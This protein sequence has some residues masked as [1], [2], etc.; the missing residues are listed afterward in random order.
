MKTNRCELFVIALL[1]VLLCLAAGRLQAAVP[2]SGT[3]GPSATDTA[4]TGQF[5]AVA[6]TTV[7]EECPAAADPANLLC[8]H[9]FLTVDVAPEYW[10]THTGGVEITIN[11]GDNGND[12]DMYVYDSS[13]V[14]VGSSGAGGTTSERVFI[15]EASGTYEVRVVPFLIVNSGYTGAAGF[16]AQDGGPAPNPVRSDGGLRFS[17]ATV[18]DAQRTEGEPL[19]YIDPA[20]NY[21][22]SGPY[23]A[24]TAQ[25][26]IHRSVDAGLQFNIVSPIGLRP[27]LPPGGGDTDLVVDDQG[28]AY[29][30]DL[31]ALI[32][33]GVAVSNDNGN[34]W[35]KNILGVAHTIDDR[36]WFAGDNGT[37]PAAS[38]NTVFLAYRQVPLGSFIFSTPGSTGF[39]DPVGGLVYQ[40]ASADPVNAVSQGAPCG[41][42]RFDP[43]HRNLYYPCGAG[44]HV[45]I[46][47]GHV[48]PGQRTGIEFYNVQ[49][50]ASPGGGPVGDIFPG[51]AVDRAG[52][53]YATW[54]DETDHNVYFAVS[55]DQ[56]AT[57]GPALQVNGN[58]ANSN[59]FPWVQAGEE[60]QIV[61]TWLGSTSHLDSDNMPSWY[62]DRNAAAAFPWFG[63]VA[64][65]RDAHTATPEFFQQRFTDKPMHYGE[66]CNSGLACST[67]GGD[68]TMADFFAVALDVDGAMR[69]VYNDT[70]SQHHGAHIFEVR[71]LGGPTAVGTTLNRPA[72]ANPM[73]DATGDAQSPHYQPFLGAGPSLPQFDFTELRLSQPDTDTLRV[74]MTVQDLSDL[75]PPQG[76]ASSLWLT[77]FQA[78]SLG[79]NGEESYRIFYV[80]AESLGGGEP[81]FFAGSGISAQDSIPGNGCTTTSGENCK[82][83]QYPAEVAADGQLVGNTIRIDVSLSGGFGAGRPLLDDTLYY[84]TAL[85][86]GRNDSDRDLYADLDATPSFNVDLS[87]LPPPPGSGRKI[88]GGGSIDGANVGDGKFNVN[89]FDTL[90]GK[91]NYKDPGAGVDFRSTKIESVSFDDATNRGI[92]TGMGVDNG[93]AVDFTATFV[94]NGE[95][96]RDDLFSIELNSG[97]SNSGQ[98]TKGNIQFHRP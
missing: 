75:T 72:P 52:N 24:S 10:D 7:P 88:T 11:W 86:A 59:V 17:P 45:E 20:G 19:N 64:L 16:V 81:F 85:S 78:L 5:Y 2:A 4:W 76:K 9:F 32:N 97:Y 8:D 41:Q 83:V 47:V 3:V 23:G 40:N 22:E 38:D 50:P 61:V 62:N 14:Q 31:E 90:K 58:E 67:S 48:N 74:E 49:A 54:V 84:V 77:R 15:D 37:T 73:A 1:M 70:T 96:G 29:F 71:Q 65:I 66:I 82:I 69:F 46:T 25:S 94:D 92:V 28:F 53:L 6:A 63:Y 60:G 13:G 21:W 51:V 44:D 57:W 26:F 93:L 80:G 95:P 33:L 36:Q 87:A 56:G 39:G 18:V 98:L 34:T 68:R 79:D 30:V 27:D 43:L 55:A 91:V 89:V 42:M 12:F 35:T